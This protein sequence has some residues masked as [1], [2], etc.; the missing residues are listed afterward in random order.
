[1]ALPGL[2][3]WFTW[4]ALALTLAVAGLAVVRLVVIARRAVCAHCLARR[5]CPA[6][7][8]GRPV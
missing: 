4:T 6:A 3:F 1:L 2:V 7:R 8:S 5:W